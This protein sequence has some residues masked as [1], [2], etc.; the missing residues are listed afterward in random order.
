MFAAA[1]LSGLMS[2]A[3]VAPDFKNSIDSQSEHAFNRDVN[4][5]AKSSF[6]GLGSPG[7]WVCAP[8]AGANLAADR[9]S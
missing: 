9:L 4:P 1:R 7:R 8:E 5:P 2:R 3:L 6:V